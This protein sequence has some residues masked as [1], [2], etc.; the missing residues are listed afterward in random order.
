[1]ARVVTRGLTETAAAIKGIT[2]GLDEAARRIA[3][4]DAA[5]IES[6]AKRNFSGSHS[7]GE[8]HVGGDQPNVVTGALR[9]SIKSDPAMKTAG[10]WSVK[11]GPTM[12]YGRR[13]ELGYP[14]GGGGRGHQKTRPFPYLGPSVHK[15]EAQ[16][17]AVAL[18]EW[19]RVL[20]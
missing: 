19:S 1:M 3:V 14:G 17:F 12:I 10:G 16:M 13:V 6:A 9:R 8:P 20:G 18:A 7:I 2:V 11:V 4:L 5:L 15:V